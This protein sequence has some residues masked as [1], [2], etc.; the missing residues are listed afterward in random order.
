MS[1][2]KTG[3]MSDQ[4]S[5]PTSIFGLRLWVVLGFCV[6]AA[7]V[8]ILFLITLWLASKRSKSIKKSKIPVVSKEIQEIRVESIK[9][10]RGIQNDPFPDPEIAAGNERQALLLMPPE[11]ESPMGYHGIQIDIGKG[12]L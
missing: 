3:L 6:G 2:Q 1:D 11:E 9:P 7:F 10:H 5:K 12:H 4:L 8:L